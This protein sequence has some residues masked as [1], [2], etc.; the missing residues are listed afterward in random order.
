MNIMLLNFYEA[1]WKISN[2]VPQVLIWQWNDEQALA[3]CARMRPSEDISVGGD[4]SDEG[5]GAG[6]ARME[7][8]S[9]RS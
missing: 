1:N 7:F 2:A 3:E 9:S 8:T 4:D 6:K 5:V